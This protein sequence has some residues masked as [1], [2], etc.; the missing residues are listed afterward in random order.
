MGLEPAGEGGTFF[1]TLPLVLRAPDG[2]SRLTIDDGS[3]LQEGSDFVP[4]RPFGLAPFG[5]RFRGTDIPVVYGGRLGDAMIDPVV[6]RGKLVLLAPRDRAGQQ[7]GPPPGV[8]ERYPEAAGFAIAGMEAL[9]SAAIAFLGQPRLVLDDEVSAPA[10][11]AVMRLTSA[12]AERMLGAKLS[13]LS[14]GAE[15]R[16]VSGTFGFSDRKT[17]AATRNV[18]ALVRGTSQ[19]LRGQMVALGAHSDH[20]GMTPAPIDHDSVFAFNRVLRMSGAN[21]PPRM[22]NVDERARIAQIRDSLRARRPAKRDSIFNG[23]DDDASGTAVLLELAEHFVAH[24]PLRSLLFVWHNA[25][26]EGLFGSAYFTDHPTVALDS[27][28]AQVN[29]DQVSRGG[30]VDIPGSQ[31]HT[32]Y[33]LGPR[34]LSSELGDLVD[35]VNARP[36]H[37][38]V[39]DRSIDAPGHPANGWCRSDHY[40]YARYGIP[41]AFFTA[42]WHPDYHMVTDETA[43]VSGE[44]MF[45]VA[46][47]VRD[48]VSRIASLDH[49][50]VVDKVRQSD[51]H[52]ACRQ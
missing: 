9:S 17:D 20:I 8:L 44:T 45:G 52:G 50:P 33:V 51:P 12:A 24:P 14:P 41:V 46:T 30:P 25:E 31:P 21:A 4:L 13:T 34:R 15:G 23:A 32:L 5:A 42:G 22:P 35:S 39:L 16:T 37:R 27:I 36:E 19:A 2:G 40:M 26:E 48:L 3:V 11:I 10:T 18:I 29:L 1:Q 28:V 43:Y 49:R 47:F 7:L 6:A 38:F